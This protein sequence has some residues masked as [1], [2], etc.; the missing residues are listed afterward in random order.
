[1]SRNGDSGPSCRVLDLNENGSCASPL[2]NVLALGLTD[3]YI[4]VTCE[5][6]SI[7]YCFLEYFFFYQEWTKA[8]LK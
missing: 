8:V 6:V 7:N 4:Q 3:V 5:E 1:M 2:T